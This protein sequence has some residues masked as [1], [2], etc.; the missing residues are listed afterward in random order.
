MKICLVSQEYPPETARGGIG[1]QTWN[2]AQVLTDLGHE[3]HVLSCAESP[4]SPDLRTGSES[5]VTV[6]RMRPPDSGT[7]VYEEETYWFG[8]TWS[9]FRHLSRL[10]ETH[11]YDVLDFPEYGAE[12]FAFQLDRAHWGRVP[13]VVHLHG[14][15]AMFSERIGW[16]DPETEFFRLATFMERLSIQRADALISSSENIADFTAAY[17]GADRA[18]IEVVHG[19][20]D[21]D[22]FAPMPQIR[23][24]RRPTVLFVGNIADNK[25][26]PTL[27]DAVIRLRAK[28]PDI[29][30]QLLGKGDDSIVRNLRRR[31][32]EAGAGRNIRFGGF[33]KERGELPGHYARADVFCSP[34]LHEKGVASVYVEA[35]ACGCPV[36]ASTTGGAPEAVE[37][38][39]SGLL[40]PPHDVEATAAALDAILGDPVTRERMSIA[41]RQRAEDY[42]ALE[43]FAERVLI[44]YERAVERFLER[45][46]TGLNRNRWAG[47]R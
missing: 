18:G 12:G 8:Y 43:K 20:I 46:G 3:V 1:S 42:F 25:G 15:L 44:G 5:G 11:R 37:H 4:D 28:Y 29:L 34:A 47:S 2:K 30:L 41:A 19:G 39:V 45:T 31:S 33:V 27:V 13:T 38:G 26:A 7:A 40:V 24:S 23:R 14:P 10:V 9:V 35:M 22:E 16:P 32:R 17:Y 6:H 21:V 36:V